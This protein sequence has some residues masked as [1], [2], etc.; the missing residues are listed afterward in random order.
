MMKK[1]I[2]S[3]GLLLS[4]LLLVA[5]SSIPKPVAELA[6]AQTLIESAET[7]EAGSYAPVELDRA[8]GKLQRAKA[9][10]DRRDY[11][12][13]TQLAN[14]AQADAKLAATKATAARVQQSAKE[15]DAT[16]KGMANELERAQQQ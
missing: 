1:S 5:C 8:K 3:L 13:A 14:E 7:S 15:M 10:V 6:S 4:T 9:A 16:V 11:K 2:T 12:T